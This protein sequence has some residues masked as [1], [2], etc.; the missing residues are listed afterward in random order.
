MVG[1]RDRTSVKVIAQSVLL[2]QSRLQAA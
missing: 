1:L 2:D